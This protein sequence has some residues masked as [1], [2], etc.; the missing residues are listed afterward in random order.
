MESRIFK[1]SKVRH[2]AKAIT[3]RVI[4][5]GTTVALALVFGLPM[6]TAGWLAVFDAVLKLLF[7][8]AHER[9]WFRV[10]LGLQR[11]RERNSE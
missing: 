4:A 11:R 9:A 6:K 2:I 8:Y 7:Y 10:D 1:S 3:W 5:T